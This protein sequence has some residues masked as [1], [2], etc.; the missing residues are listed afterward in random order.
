MKKKIYIGIYIGMSVKNFIG[1]IRYMEGNN[2]LL[3]IPIP[4]GFG[5]VIESSDWFNMFEEGEPFCEYNGQTI[6]FLENGVYSFNLYGLL[7]RTGYLL[8]TQNPA[9]GGLD[10]LEQPGWSY[11]SLGV[12]NLSCSVA[13]RAGEVWYLKAF[14][15]PGG[16]S[17]LGARRFRI[18]KIT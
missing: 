16:V 17:S 9:A 6:T 13:I 15:D 14:N 1:Q 5:I 10:T 12:V 7:D 4:D 18:T 11:D 3:P 8:I 2:F